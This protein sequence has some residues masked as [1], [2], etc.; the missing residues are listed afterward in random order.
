[1]RILLLVCALFYS[2][3]QIVG[4]DDPRT[5]GNT[6]Y[7]AQWEAFQD[8]T[9]YYTLSRS[10]FCLPG[11][12]MQV[13][14]VQGKVTSAFYLDRQD[15]ITQD[16]LDY[17]ETIDAMFDLIDER[18]GN[19]YVFEV[20]YSDSGYPTSITLDG[21]EQI[22]DDELWLEVTDLHVGVR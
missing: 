17:I 5:N 20:E 2:G 1:M 3:C 13:Q 21:S 16:Q 18:Q 8:G 10:C 22:A 12:R 15:E 6:D 7:R 4:P 9:Y 14:V 11:G 19:S